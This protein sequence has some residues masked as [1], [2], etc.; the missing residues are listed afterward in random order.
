[1]RRALNKLRKSPRGNWNLLV[2]RC[3]WC[4]QVRRHKEYEWE[5]RDVCIDAYVYICP[6]CADAAFEAAMAK[7]L[8]AEAAAAARGMGFMPERNRRIERHTQPDRS[9]P[10]QA[11]DGRN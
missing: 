5:T 8:E 3:A 11:H 6:A 7:E 2:G 10:E 9:E 4:R 1:M